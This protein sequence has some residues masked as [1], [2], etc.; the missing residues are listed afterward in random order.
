MKRIYTLILCVISLNGFS[1]SR[2]LL[3]TANG[4]QQIHQP[5]GQT[6]DNRPPTSIDDV[7]ISQSLSGLSYVV[8][9]STP[10]Q[11]IKIGGDE[12]S[13]CR[14]MHISNTTVRFYDSTGIDIE[15]AVVNVYTSNGGHVLVDSGAVID[16]GRFFLYGGNPAVKDLVVEDSKLGYTTAHN[17]DWVDL[18]MED[19]GWASIS[20]SSF[21]GIYLETKKQ[22]STGGLY[23]NNSTFSTSSFILGDNTI[24]TFLNSS[25]ALKGSNVDLDFLIGKNAHFVSKNDTIQLN[26]GTLN[27]ISSGS[28]FNGNITSWYMNFQQEDPSN[29]LPNII[30]GDILLVEEPG[31]GISGDVKISGNLTDHMPSFAFT[32]Y[33]SGVFLDSQY[34]F[35]IGGIKNFGKDV[36]IKNCMSNFCHYKLEFFGDKNSYIDWNLGFPIDTLVINKTNCAKVSSKN[37]L[38]VAGETRIESG[39]LS[40]DPIDSLPYEFVSAGNVK[41]FPG[42]GIFLKKDATGKVAN[43]AIAGTLVDQNTHPGDSS[44]SGLSNPYN[45]KI[46]FY[47]L[48]SN[49]G[50]MDS[51]STGNTDTT[52]TGNTD[53]TTTGNTDTLQIVHTDSLS[54]FS[55]NYSDRSVT[56]LWT[57]QKQ[58]KTK[59]FSIEK[60]FNQSAFSSVKDVMATPNLP[61]E[62]DYQYVDNSSLQKVNYYR[63]RMVDV[64]NNFYYSDTISV[65]G[66]DKRV[67]LV[68]P[69]PAK[70]QLFLRLPENATDADVRI[71]DF[72]GAVVKTIKVTG[73]GDI[74][75]NTSQ[76]QRGN[77]SI[78]IHAGQ[79]E[80]TVPFIKE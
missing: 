57:M 19:S 58:S 77:Y 62:N 22:G 40:L 21:D 70:G 50:K 1:Q 61:T 78:V 35:S 42:G 24:D 11:P 12:S 36:W 5:A 60:S 53:T 46:D 13:F 37:A 33:G 41:I 25:I 56:L 54:H 6:P 43:I 38:Y 71:I 34:V 66:P 67:I 68:Y 80:K 20:R 63:L 18:Y 10:G 72:K 48:T 30:N 51:T 69:N 75:I 16:M 2:T 23:A 55:A 17:I 73:T 26:N 44:C 27:F 79:M 7:V 64:N 31:A 28:V 14:S 74:P 29:P 76:L 9:E 45:G 49:T 15:G 65:A 32:D 59:L 47:K 8:I 4:W 3:Y 52:T 39:E